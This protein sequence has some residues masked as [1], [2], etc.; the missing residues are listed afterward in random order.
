[1]SDT[2]QWALLYASAGYPVVPLYTTVAPAPA[3]TVAA[4]Q[5]RE[6]SKKEAVL[7][8]RCSCGKP[9]CTSV[10]KHPI[11]H[12]GVGE[13]TTDEKTIRAWWERWP[14][15]N[16]GLRMPPGKFVVDFDLYEDG[17]AERR[18]ALRATT[19]PT[20]EQRSGMGEHWVFTYTGEA[21]FA[22]TLDER[23]GVDIIHPG[24]RY[25]VA[26]PSKHWSGSVYDWVDNNVP[27]PVEAPAEL[28]SRAQRG[29]RRVAT[30]APRPPNA[31]KY[32]GI[33]LTPPPFAKPCPEGTDPK[34]WAVYL[35]ATLPPAVANEVGVES[36]E[37]GHQTLARV[38][39][40]LVAGL[41][42][43]V[44]EAIDV[45]WQVYNPRCVPPWTDEDFPDFERTILTSGKGVE[46]G[47]LLP[48]SAKPTPE[49]PPP[50]PDAPHPLLKYG[51]LV[52]RTKPP[53]PLKYVF[54]LFDFAPGKVSAIQAYAYSAKT[55]FALQ[56]CLCVAAG[57]PFLGHPVTQ[58]NAVFCAF[59][60]GWLAEE[61]EARVAA[62]LGLDRASVPLDFF[63][64]HDCLSEPFV[65]ALEDWV[66]TR[67]IGLVTIDTY[68][69]AV[70]AGVD[71]NSSHFSDWLKRLGKL[72]DET[73]CL[74]VVLIHENKS[75]DSGELRGVSGHNSLGGAVQA[76]VQL[77]RPGEDKTVLE[78]V[79][80]RAVRKPFDK[81][82]IRWTDP[83][84]PDAPTGFGLVAERLD[85]TS[86]AAPQPDQLRSLN[87]RRAEQAKMKDAE[88]REDI[89]EWLKEHRLCTGDELIK[90]ACGGNRAS[91]YRV[92]KTLR[93]QGYVVTNGETYQLSNKQP[94][95]GQAFRRG[96]RTAAE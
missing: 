73:G 85:G 6:I 44:R 27:D 47:Y 71:H 43:D 14:E 23:P 2:L 64:F 31:S 87:D 96:L 57:V 7:Q 22:S 84:C 42:L 40:S 58:C 4:F 16:V 46:P 95:P 82:A 70:P 68:G 18:D 72:S 80:S 45:L 36:K 90:H 10:G 37:H 67:Q 53:V 8:A 78:V 61:R 5:R 29:A 76:V 51:V 65:T 20:L 49:P 33:K 28:L 94:T 91:F 77:Q 1:M 86:T 13:A 35:A 83:I 39:R 69:A 62:G 60:G 17:V 26:A 92:I 54:E 24:H 74:I 19:P 41:G 38:G 79:S 56:F 59:E 30:T 15:A 88:N 66:R 55:P 89:I 48:P 12:N 34:T 21:N 25:I 11:P 93:I 75:A 63:K 3:E 52:D 81:F 50:D 32:Y 9:A